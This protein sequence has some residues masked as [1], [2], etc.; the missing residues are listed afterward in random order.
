MGASDGIFRGSKPH[1]RGFGTFPRIVGDHV[2]KGT[3]TL[4][5]AVHG[6]TGRPA[7]RFKLD[8]RGRIGAAQ[9]AD[10]VVFDP[11]TLADATSWNAPR[12]RSPGIHSVLVNG[13]I[14][15]EEGTL[16]GRLPGRILRR[17]P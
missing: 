8:G 17:A 3:L 11:E 12:R 13:E 5:G 4:E 6:V 2:R 16:T 15:L 9:F 7:Q 10:L 1:R 14:V